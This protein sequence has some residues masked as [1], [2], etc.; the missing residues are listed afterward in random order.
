MEAGEAR[1]PG[2][3]G[4]RATDHPPLGTTQE[5]P[6]RQHSRE[7]VVEIV[8]AGYAE[9]M[10]ALL[11]PP[12]KRARTEEHIAEYLGVL[13]TIEESLP[14]AAGVGPTDEAMAEMRAFAGLQSVKRRD[15]G[16]Y[17][18]PP[19]LSEGESKVRLLED[20]IPSGNA[21]P[22]KEEREAIRLRVKAGEL[23]LDELELLAVET[24]NRALAHNTYRA[25][26]TAARAWGDYFDML[27]QSDQV[28]SADTEAAKEKARKLLRGFLTYSS[29]VVEGKNP[30]MEGVG[31]A[32]TTATY[33]RANLLNHALPLYGV[34]LSF[35]REEIKLWEKGQQRALNSVYGIAT[36]MQ[37]AGFTREHLKGFFEMDWSPYGSTKMQ[38]V[39]KAA[40]L[41]AFVGMLRRSEYTM[42]N[43]PFNPNLSMNRGSA[44]WYFKGHP[45][46]GSDP[47]YEDFKEV[48]PWNKEAATDLKRTGAGYGALTVGTSKCD[49]DAD[50][51]KYPILLPLSKDP[52]GLEA[53]NRLLDME[54][55]DEIWDPE[56]RA[57][58]PLFREV[59]VKKGEPHQLRTS[60]FD[61]VVIALMMGWYAS[62][63]DP[64]DEKEVRYLYSL[65]SFRIGGV[66]ALKAA[67]VPREL[68][69]LM[70][71]W[72]SMAVDTYTRQEIVMSLEWLKLPETAGCH[73]YTPLTLDMPQFDEAEGLVMGDDFDVLTLKGEKLKAREPDPTLEEVEGYYQWL[74]KRGRMTS[75]GECHP[76][77]GRRVRMSFTIEADPKGKG[78][79]RKQ[80]ETEW[81]EGE[82][83][84]VDREGEEPVQVKF[85]GEAEMLHYGYE[86]VLD[87][88]MERE[89]S[90][91]E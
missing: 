80:V 50:W 89:S 9:T 19:P 81:Y 87:S 15:T 59:D 56:E 13:P 67:G 18:P 78:K 32:H 57:K 10:E 51:S 23:T 71:R 43:T 83:Q 30:K 11:N 4:C 42:G 7:E 88:L 65:H 27:G 58:T 6:G 77:V 54:L 16:Y 79:K 1:L 34:D 17:Q 84:S 38:S 39:L 12:A 14:S 20:A 66:N 35:L 33:A 53:G 40:V 76:L 85:D 74:E 73:L 36:R 8:V 70:G 61:K 55:E 46:A 29:Y 64:K 62:K 48:T 2:P 86:Y 47:R 44:K 22:S 24:Q 25:R 72:K 69:M 82:I 28:L 37:K 45:K 60:R 3:L 49:P 52:T 91:E 75:R 31:Q 21:P 26:R 68:R 90:E 41:V 63:G 5:K